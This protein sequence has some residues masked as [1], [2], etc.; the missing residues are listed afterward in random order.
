MTTKMPLEEYL[1]RNR[2][3]ARKVVTRFIVG[4]ISILTLSTGALY[5]LPKVE[6]WSFNRAFYERMNPVRD[7]REM[8]YSG[9]LTPD[10]FFNHPRYAGLF[11][12]KMIQTYS[13]LHQHIV[14]S[15][16]FSTPKT[17]RCDLTDPNFKQPILD[18]LNL[19]EQQ[20]VEYADERGYRELCHH[21]ETGGEIRFSAIDGQRTNTA[22]YARFISGLECELIEK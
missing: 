9:K 2:A 11:N 4:V 15:C 1:A 20:L 3:I 16:N 19:L 13:E 8:V 5:I 18:K 12:A 17:N 21:K 6:N 10:D 14:T 22:E 7:W